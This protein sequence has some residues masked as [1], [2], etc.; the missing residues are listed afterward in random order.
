[1]ATQVKAQPTAVECCVRISA[2]RLSRK[3]ADATARL[4]K[5]LADP[6]R[7]R[8]V[9]L[10]SNA[11]EPVCVCD[12]TPQIGLA[13]PTT[14]FHLKKLVDSGLVTREQRGVWAYYSLAA[15]ALRKLQDV[16]YFKERGTR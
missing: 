10:L 14:S 16:V 15:P 2:P 3:D 8:I 1:M 4:F 5:A 12:I 6:H 13:Q 9:N 11:G 7:L